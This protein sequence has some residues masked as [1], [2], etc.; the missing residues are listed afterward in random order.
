VHGGDHA[1]QLGL[2]IQASSYPGHSEAAPA[3]DQPKLIVINPWVSC[4]RPV[5]ASSGVP[6]ASIY[7]RYRAGDSVSQLANDFC[8]KS[9]R[10]KKRS[11]AKP[12]EGTV[13]FLDRSLGV[14]P[15][16]TE[17]RTASLHVTIHAD[18]FRPDE[19]DRR[20]HAHQAGEGC[21]RVT[22]I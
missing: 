7:D 20:R 6:A 4:G 8:L 3:E 9:V 5:V 22:L 16:R 12:R 2:G 19:E 18:H 10:S 17:L 1:P 14:E 13:F 15:L 21:A 11:A